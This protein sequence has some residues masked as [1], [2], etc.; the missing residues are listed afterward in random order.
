MQTL[1]RLRSTAVGL[2]REVPRTTFRLPGKKCRHSSLPAWWMW[3]LRVSSVFQP[4]TALHDPVTGGLCYPCRSF[5]EKLQCN[6]TNVGSC[7]QRTEILAAL[8]S[9]CYYLFV[10][11]CICITS[12]LSG[13]HLWL[14][15]INVSCDNGCQK[16][17]ISTCRTEIEIIIF[18]STN[19]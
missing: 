6:R 14:L 9:C 7:Y 8:I 17:K 5:F 13:L 2:N 18:Y 19:P 3:Q 4:T 11:K 16:K 12:F 1:N 15:N 10:Q